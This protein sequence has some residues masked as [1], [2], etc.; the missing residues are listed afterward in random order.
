ML[1]V[2]SWSEGLSTIRLKAVILTYQ[3]LLQE[4][5]AAPVLMPRSARRRSPPRRRSRSRLLMSKLSYLESGSFLRIET[6]DSYFYLIRPTITCRSG[7]RR[8]SPHRGGRSPPR[9]GYQGGRR[10]SP[11]PRRRS[12]PRRRSRLAVSFTL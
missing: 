4:I 3:Y 8:R 7:G 12:P 9:R 5:S 6:S 11:S 10:R 1:A 2:V